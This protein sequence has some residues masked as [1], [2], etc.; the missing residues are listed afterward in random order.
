MGKEVLREMVLNT[1]IKLEFGL[2]MKT[3]KILQLK[4]ILLEV[5]PP[6]VRHLVG[7]SVCLLKHYKRA[8]IYT[9]LILLVHFFVIRHLLQI[10]QYQPHLQLLAQAPSPCQLLQEYWNQRH[11]KPLAAMLTKQRIAC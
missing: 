11:P 8:G 9:S 5:K 3:V 2:F 1:L 4:A 10:L 6:H 7:R